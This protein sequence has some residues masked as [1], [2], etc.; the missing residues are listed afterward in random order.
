MGLWRERNFFYKGS[1]Q[2][3]HPRAD[4]QRSPM[5]KNLAHFQLAESL[6]IFMAYLSQQ[7]SNVG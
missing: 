5:G 7:N 4:K 2:H 1:I 6:Y 3:H